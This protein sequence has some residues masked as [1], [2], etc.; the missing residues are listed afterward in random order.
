LEI[1]I[2]LW[3]FALTAVAVFGLYLSVKGKQ[4]SPSD[5]NLIL[6]TSISHLM[7]LIKGLEGRLLDV[8][9]KV[10][11]LL[12]EVNKSKEADKER[13][14]SLFE[15]IRVLMNSQLKLARALGKLHEKLPCIESRIEKIENSVRSVR[16]REVSLPSPRR[17]E[18]RG[19]EV[20][21]T[22]LT[23]TEM[24]ILRLLYISGP[25]TA[26]EVREVI[27]KTREHTARLMK[28]L[29]LEGYV[30]RD[31]QAI[32]FVYRLSERIK[33]SMTFSVKREES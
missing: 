15:N 27:G 12:V 6:Q 13:D 18:V 33:K 10:D 3:L 30:E 23:P 25:K 8:S 4:A 32:P 28:K 5:F 9:G 16:R 22:S 14:S 21:L 11:G 20:S 29:T 26:S 7:K 17:I 1:L 24:E 2:F 31:T 19:Q